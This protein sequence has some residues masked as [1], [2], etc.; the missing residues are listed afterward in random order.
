MKDEAIAELELA[1]ALLRELDNTDDAL[2]H[3]HHAVERIRE[4]IWRR[5]STLREQMLADP[6]FIKDVKQGYEEGLRDEGMSIEDY[7]QSRS[8]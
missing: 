7:R 5:N 2:V 4:I 1:V 8:L 6:Q 3:A